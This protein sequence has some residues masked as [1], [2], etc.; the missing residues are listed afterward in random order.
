M[1]QPVPAAT[2]SVWPTADDAAELEIIVADQAK[3]IAA[4]AALID[5]YQVVLNNAQNPAPGPAATGTGT[6]SGTSLTVSGSTG[7][8]AVGATVADAGTTTTI[9][10]GTKILGQISGTTG[11]DGVYLTNNVTTTSATPLTFT[12]PPPASTWPIP[13]DAPTLQAIQIAQTGM[14]RLQSSLI[15]QYIDLLNT[16]ET[17]VPVPPP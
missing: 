8:I 4:Q 1:L 15:Q 11:A 3:T 10:A 5:E 17:P 13:G 16:S 2:T 9:P 6:S 7:V 12:P 14:I